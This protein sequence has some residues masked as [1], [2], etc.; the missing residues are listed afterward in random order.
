MQGVP[1]TEANLQEAIA[2]LGVSSAAAVSAS[3]SAST[4]SPAAAAQL[5]QAGGRSTAAAAAAAAATGPSKGSAD[6]W[7]VP[8]LPRADSTR[9]A[10]FRLVKTM[11]FRHN[12]VAIFG[13]DLLE[14]LAAGQISTA[15]ETNQY[16]ENIF[17]RA[18]VISERARK[19]A[20]KMQNEWRSEITKLAH[21]IAQ[22]GAHDSWFLPRLPRSDST[23][24]SLLRIMQEIRPTIR[25]NFGA[26]GFDPTI[27]ECSDMIKDLTAGQINTAEEVNEKMEGFY[28]SAMGE[29]SFCEAAD[30]RNATAFRDQWRS[31]IDQLAKSIASGELA[32]RGSTAAAA[33]AA[34]GAS[35]APR[36][37]SSADAARASMQQHAATLAA[38]AAPAAAAAS[39]P[40]LVRATSSSASS[41]DAFG[42]LRGLTDE[43]AEQSAT[44]QQRIQQL[45]L[46]L[47]ARSDELVQAQRHGQQ[48]AQQ[49]ELA[50]Q[51]CKEQIITVK[52][53]KFDVEEQKVA[54]GQLK[55]K[56]ESELQEESK[57]HRVTADRASE[58]A[59]ANA[60][61]ESEK[62]ELKFECCICADARPSVLYLPCSHLKVCDECDVAM[63]AAGQTCPLCRNPIEKRHRGLH[64]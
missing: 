14:N 4:S 63:E 39:S 50:Q 55:R 44:A 64:L 22:S 8:W 10:I 18:S 6:G 26:E 37:A 11:S 1:V 29:Y 43:L 32:M 59:A 45:E 30:R 5:A 34:T 40:S 58:L 38:A 16:V 33:L 56:A 57:K 27:A 47:Q 54:V 28:A 9:L 15:E 48:L 52:R 19:G 21:S 60:Q 49:L 36:P 7:V 51:Q 35:S 17:S 12:V 46:Q 3:A 31:N 53:E 24:L 20:V 25:G 23:R 61:L 13:L 42:R 62:E 41:L 2:N